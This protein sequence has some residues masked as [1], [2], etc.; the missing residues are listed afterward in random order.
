MDN[1]FDQ[2]DAPASTV[3]TPLAAGQFG[4]GTKYSAAQMAQLNAARDSLRTAEANG[5]PATYGGEGKPNP[6][7]QFDAAPA[8]ANP[9]A[10]LGGTLQFGIPYTGARLDT[11]IPLP[12][13]LEAALV[14]AGKSTSNFVRGIT[15]P[16]TSVAQDAQVAADNAATAPLEAAHPLATALGGIAPYMATANPMAMAAIAAA[17]YGTPGQRAENAAFTYGGAKVGQLAGRLLGPS[18]MAPVASNGAEDFASYPL[19]AGNK[20][21]IP[22][23]VAQTTDNVPLKIID[24]VAANLPISSGVI[25]K[26]KDAS[27]QGFNR[28][29]G[30]TFGANTTQ[31]TPEL[32]GQ[33]QQSIGSTIGQLAARNSLNLDPQ[34]AQDIAAVSQRASK[35]LSTSDAQIVGKQ[36][37]ELLSKVDPNTGTIPGTNY[38]A[39]RSDLGDLAASSGGT[40]GNVLGDLRGAVTR[41]MDRSITPEDAQAWAQANRQ[42]FNVNQVANAA[43]ATPGSLSPAQLLQ[44]VNSAQRK[45]RFGGGNDLAELAQFAKPVLG[46]S[47]PNSGTA[48]RLFYQK[49]LTNPLTTIGSIGGGLYGANELGLN[50]MDIA[51]GGLL[52]YG[53]ARGMAGKPA[54]LLTRRLL[55]QGGGLLGYSSAQ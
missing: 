53:A 35:N 28:A 19:S 47:I 9:D 29:V 45:A 34:L 41:G 36:I 33:A 46:D 52:A 50:P 40:L 4:P 11:H 14:S 13:S 49:M 3:G 10:A 37:D 54:S 42:Y 55:T 16:T 38:R 51:A 23:R 27:F 20:F 5:D 25:S 30:N 31:I 12:A 17:G 1:V 43:K 8:S 26:A 32:L 18:S 15:H 7:D 24:S 22:L 21:G 2:F 6:F 44:A 39:F 48:Q